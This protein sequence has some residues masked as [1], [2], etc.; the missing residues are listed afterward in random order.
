MGD[1]KGLRTFPENLIPNLPSELP[2]SPT[3]PR[4]GISAN[5]I[6]MRA[7]FCI[8][9]REWSQDLQSNIPLPMDGLMVPDHPADSRVVHAEVL[10]DCPHRVLSR[11]VRAGHR[12]VARERLLEVR[13][14]LARCASLSPRDLCQ[15][16][17]LPDPHLHLFDETLRT[18]VDLSAQ[19]RPQAGQPGA[20]V[21]KLDVLAN[22]ARPAD[23]NGWSSGTRLDTPS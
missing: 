16:G 2:P 1:D 19:P 15:G 3:L 7:I 5:I 21:H 10:R 13:Q 11:E 9:T 17:L 12:F 22:G 4:K 6:F 14:W 23:G 20:F 18:Q 8:G